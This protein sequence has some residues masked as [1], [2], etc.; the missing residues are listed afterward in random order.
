MMPAAKHGDPQLGI[1]IHLCEVPPSPEPVPLPTPH[2]S[3]VFDPFDYL[4]IIG[5]SV[6]VCGMLRANAGTSGIAFHIPLGFPFSEPLPQEND[7]IFM[8]S[9]T[10]GADGQPFSSLAMPV[11]SCQMIG[12]PSIPRVPKRGTPKINLLPTTVN[13]AIPTNVFVGGPPTVSWFAL[14][15][16]AGFA[17]LGK[18]AKSELFARIRKKLFGEMKPG[19]LKCNILR[20]EPVNILT[21]HVWMEQLDFELP[22]R[23]P[24]RWARSYSSGR[25]RGGECGV[26]W[27]SPADGRLEIERDGSVLMQFPE[28]GPL[29][30]ERLPRGVGEAASELELLDGARLTDRGDAYQVHTKGDRIYCFPKDLSRALPEGG[31]EIALERIEDLCGNWMRLQR[32]GRQLIAL[33]FSDGRQVEI[34][35][36]AGAR[37]EG[38]AMHLPGNGSPHVFVRYEYDAAGDLVEVLDA[39][40]HAY[41]FAYDETHRMVRHTDRNGLSFY[42]TF[43]V[44]GRVEHA[45]GDGGLYD[46]HFEYNETLRER[47]IT[48]SLGHVSTVKLDDRDLP[49]SEV[50]T[51]G[52]ITSYLYDESG[53]TVAVVDPAG[54]RTRYEYDERGNLLKLIRADGSVMTLEVNEG[55]KPTAITDANGA[56]WRQRW[57]ERG[58]LTKWT[59]PLGAVTTYEYEPDGLLR[60]V[61]D[62][63]QGTT[64]LGYDRNGYLACVTDALGHKSRFER[65]ELGHVLRHLDPLGRGTTYRYDAKGRLLEALLAGGGHV[66]CKWGARDDLLQYEDEQGAVTRFDYFGQ[67]LVAKRYQSDGHA[68]AYHYDSEEQL[69]GVSNQRGE[70]YELKRDALGR[71]VEE[72][73]YWGQ[74][75]RYAFNLAGHLQQSCDPL[76]C[77]IDYTTDALGRVTRKRFVHPDDTQRQFEEVFE[78]DAGG[79]LTGCANE[80]VSVRRSFDAEG[81]LLQERQNGFEV[82]NTFDA[83]GRR[84]RCEASGHV[85]AYGYDALGQVAT[86]QIDAEAPIT[87]E[88]DAAGQVSKETLNAGVERHYRYDAEGRLIAQGV[89]RG[90]QWLFHT[91]YDYDTAGNLVQRQ[92][93][94]SGIDRYRHDPLGQVIEHLDPQ[95]K[96]ERFVHDPAGDRLTTRVSGEGAWRREGWCGG[97]HYRFDAA[98]NLVERREER[99]PLGAAPQIVELDWDANQRLIR[100]RGG[101]SETVYGY[102]PLGRRVFKRTGKNTTWFGW[103]GDA[104]IAEG[105]AESTAWRAQR[106]YVYYPGTFVPLALISGEASYR[107]HT[108]PNG[109]PTR[110]TKDDGKVVWAARHDVWGRARVAVSEVAN[111]IRLQGQYEDVETGLHYNRYRYYDPMAGQFVSQDPI[112]LHGGLNTYAYGP[113]ANSWIDPLG[114]AKKPKGYDVTGNTAGPDVV[115]RGV[116]VNVEG[117]GLPREGG[118]V[119]LLPII[120]RDEKG[121]IIKTGVKLA[122][123]DVKMKGISDSVWRKVERAVT[124]HL[125]NPVNVERLAGMAR[126][127]LNQSI[128]DPE[129]I[130]RTTQLLEIL[131]GHHQAKTNPC[132]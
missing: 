131:S 104:L 16:R 106:K 36:A 114:L 35:H 82:N 11:L 42:Y 26:G 93:S 31:Y 83:L 105:P 80:H 120:E 110:L 55:N 72:V 41:R 54:R 52:G 70:C 60:T 95:G 32:R 92:D 24:L 34:L 5:G 69:I 29:S 4:P 96:L 22:G 113:N 17:A 117:P 37:I 118:H 74:V 18:F 89:Q 14:A 128:K 98:G 109:C 81:R 75:T 122:P 3:I 126:A 27:E 39:L 8:G 58:L 47:R 28:V 111:P 23:F 121:K 78:F 53:R 102:D 2:I 132:G 61:T 48:N 91:Q 76:G 40:N 99:Q 129:R 6:Y 25:S 59:S 1:D 10:V 125:N 84:V 19:F 12:M 119:E 94:H 130:K 71:V 46:Y 67:G 101:G 112:G 90:M 43:D 33:Q 77:C 66:R 65:D 108:D 115:T 38:L 97:V 7:E 103:D 87:I 100:S 116:H 20:A 30:F 79:N 51:L 124:E 64:T 21:G 13:L 73:D 85:V 123:V 45:W 9:A 88:R 62:A 56:T 63:L 57:D 127:G 15:A 44:H 68:V 50:D 49:I 86:V 107:Y